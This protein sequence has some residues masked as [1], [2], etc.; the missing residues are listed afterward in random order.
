M[1]MGSIIQGLSEITDFHIAC[2]ASEVFGETYD[3]VAA[4]GGTIAH[5]SPTPLSRMKL[6]LQ[7]YRAIISRC[8]LVH[9]YRESRFFKSQFERFN[10]DLVW[11]E[12]P[13]LLRYA[14]DWRNQ[15]PIV[16]DF[17]GTSEGQ[18]RD[19]R[20]SKGVHKL[21]QGLR[22][23]TIRGA[24]LRYVPLLKDIV[25]VSELDGRHFKQIAPGS[26]IWPIPVGIPN[27]PSI[28]PVADV[29]ADPNLLIFT[30]D[31]SFSPNVDAVVYFVK[32]ILPKIQNVHPNVRLM[33]AGRSPSRE[34]VALSKMLHVEVTGYLPDLCAEIAKAAVYILPMRLGSGFRTKLLEV[35]PLG[36]PVVTTS[37]GAEGLRLRHNENCL[38]ADDSQG[39]AEACIRLLQDADEARRLGRNIQRLAKE[40]YSQEKI[41]KL[42]KTVIAAIFDDNGVHEFI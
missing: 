24:E 17:W 34:I 39:F 3:W 33:V 5:I 11:L 22:Y 20:H 13:Y 40:V 18:E 41:A 16:V 31:M 21:W 35:F 38:I 8:N 14:I 4:H 7:R 27:Y 36:K 37:I 19:Y 29:D 23:Y 28:K 25:T 2:V 30:G 10:P 6:W 26:K 15:T 42:V 9:Y 1:R 32:A 12:T